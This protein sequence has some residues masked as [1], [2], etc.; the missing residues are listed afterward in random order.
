MTNF[1]VS[2]M[3]ANKSDTLRLALRFEPSWVRVGR[4]PRL[5]GGDSC[6]LCAL[7]LK[8]HGFRSRRRKSRPLSLG[9]PD[10]DDDDAGHQ[11]PTLV[12]SSLPIFNLIREIAQ[13]GC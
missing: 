8:R 4:R 2:G 3:L 7:E 9:H 11:Q 13:H 1:T 12:R 5:C 10:R 6:S